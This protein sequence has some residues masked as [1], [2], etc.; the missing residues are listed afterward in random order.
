M[1]DLTR[2][3][4]L[5]GIGGGI[6]AYKAAE[7]ARLMIKQGAEVRV[8]MTPSA[9]AFI[10]PLTLQAL[11]GQRVHAALMDP[12][13]ELAMGHIELARWADQVVIAPATA[14]LLA[15][16]AHGLANDLLTTLC[17]A[18][19]APLWLAPAMNHVMW[20]APATRANHALLETRGCRFLGPVSGDQACGERG[21]GRMLEPAAIVEALLAAGS[22]ARWKG[23]R[24]L[25]TAGP[26]REP[27]DPVRYLSNR[28]SGRMGF[29]LAAAAAEEGADVV[30]VSGPVSLSTPAAVRRL[31]VTEARQMLKA[32]MDEIANCDIFIAAAAVAD[33]R[34][35]K[36]S[37]Q[38]IKKHQAHLTLELERNPDILARVAGLPDPPFSVGFAAETEDLERH[39][40]DKL[41]RKGLDL[42]AANRVDIEGQGFDSER[43]ALV[44]FWSGGRRHLGLDSKDRIARN[45]LEL[46][47]E[48]YREKRRVENPGSPPR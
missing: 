5:L 28:S 29:A 23:L 15:R 37:L 47:V 4:V 33:Y 3:R 18:T 2:K 40:L 44:V 31:D 43:N 48:R 9:Q 16:L 8:V 1:G 17:L 35:Q 11:T 12:E 22:P 6:A 10:T 13:A 19:E 20:S 14:D 36:R 46:T 38:K 7:L 26:T 32:V 42:V 34:P 24:F 41:Q 30:L 39:A 21:L 25:I 27:L 45:L